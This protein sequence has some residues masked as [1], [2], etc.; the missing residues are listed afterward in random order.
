[1]KKIDKKIY[2]KTNKQKVKVRKKIP[3]LNILF[4]ILILILS[5]I[6][7]LVFKNRENLRNIF[8]NKNKIKA[9]QA[10][11]AADLNIGDI[12]Y[13]DHKRAADSNNEKKQTVTIKPGDSSHPGSGYN[14]D[15]T[16]NVKDYNTTWR[17][18][19]KKDDGSVTL[20]SNKTVATMNIKAA[21]GYIWW[22]HNAHKVASIFG[23][24]KGAD[25]GKNKAGEDIGATKGITY[26]VGSGIN[27]SPDM[28][29]SKDRGTWTIGGEYPKDEKDKINISGAKA[30]TLQE[31]EEKFEINKE[32]VNNPKNGFNTNETVYYGGP[33]Y[34]NE[35]E[36]TMTYVV[37]RNIGSLKQNWNNKE[38][39]QAKNSRYVMKDSHY[40]WNKDNIT[41][42]NIPNIKYKEILFNGM[43]KWC[44]LATNAL[45]VT[46]E[47][48]KVGYN[49]GRMTSEGLGS[50]NYLLIRSNGSTWNEFGQSPSLR[51][52]VFMNKNNNY[53]T[54]E[55]VNG[56]KAW[57]LQVPVTKEKKIEIDNYQKLD[58]EPQI[59]LVQNE[60]KIKANKENNRYIANVTYEEGIKRI[61]K[62]DD[63]KFEEINTKY[64]IEISNLPAGYTFKIEGQDTNEIDVSQKDNI[65]II[66]SKAGQDLPARD[67][68]ASDLHIGD[69][70]Y[71]N[72]KYAPNKDHEAN[73]TVTIGKGSASTPGS[74][75]TNHNP[76]P[77][78]DP[79]PPTPPPPPTP[80]VP[81][82]PTPEP[83][84]PTPEPTPYH[85]LRV[86]PPKLPD[87][88]DSNMQKFNAKEYNTTWRVWDK[89]A[90]GRVMLVSN[91]TVANINTKGAVG[92]IWWEHNAHKISSIFGYGEGADTNATK[93]TEYKVGSGI[94]D[95]PD[96]TEGDKGDWK[97]GE[98]PE[99]KI[100][101][102]G[103]RS[104]T[105]PEVEEKLGITDK[106]IKDETT[107]SWIMSS[108]PG[109]GNQTITSIAYVVQRDIESS[110]QNWKTEEDRKK[111][112]AKNKVPDGYKM[113]DKYY[114]WQKDLMPETK[115]KEMLFNQLN[116][117]G[118]LATNV[119]AVCCRGAGVGFINAGVSSG[120]VGTGGGDFL[121]YSTDSGWEERANPSNLRVA[122]YLKSK[123]RYIPAGGNAWDI[124]EASSEDK[125]VKLKVLNLSSASIDKIG[126]KAS[127]VNTD[128]VLLEDITKESKTST[129][130]NE[131]YEYNLNIKK[132]SG[133][134][135]EGE[136]D[137]ATFSIIDNKYNVEITGIPEWYDYK[138]LGKEGKQ[139]DLDE[140]RT[141]EYELVIYPKAGKQ[142]VQVEYDGGQDDETFKAKG[143]I[144]NVVI[145]S[146]GK[147]LGRTDGVTLK[148]GV[149]SVSVDNVDLF[150]QTNNSIIKKYTVEFERS[151]DDKS[152][153]TV[154]YDIDKEK[155][156][157]KY[158]SP[159]KEIMVKVAEDSKKYLPNIT[160][161]KLKLVGDWKET[162]VT[163]KPIDFTTKL[164]V[165]E[166][167][168]EGNP[169][170]YSLQKDGNV[171]GYY[172]SIDGFNVNLKQILKLPFTGT[173]LSGKNIAIISLGLFGI[174]LLFR[175]RK[176]IVLIFKEY[177]MMK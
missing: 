75:W 11:K 127:K 150:D 57:D 134:K 145:K 36:T 159:N 99:D 6:T 143:V 3:I 39:G 138:I 154:K 12:V 102:S 70:V 67:L 66:I 97:I 38:K 86:Y 167:D 175:F 148:I 95:A 81:E 37:Q 173:E 9:P 44:G 118:A 124:Y 117:Y 50:A 126:I 105:L 169:I 1:M 40:Y 14:T 19:D 119:L 48:G 69:I 54:A 107:S 25:V 59:N 111:G 84:L 112:K 78:P 83:E 122:V 170:T 120:S 149:N 121:V 101:I 123:I 53:Y 133:Q 52:M 2:K 21:V 176:K 98:E 51:V 131:K 20:I 28:E 153:H 164:N 58:F 141:L 13:Y 22:E 55:Q 156:V 8:T 163:L 10:S 174:A 56:E 68:D 45:S 103:A 130:V 166:R 137:D 85:P 162:P 47:G 27:N 49:I 7:S 16:F 42:E 34:G 80:P 165:P 132:Y 128:G 168:E 72:H 142:A 108:D 113:T 61:G 139:I 106:S 136:G 155:L 129:K 71:Y 109:Y 160:E 114:Y 63:A 157:V 26:K 93:G 125:N 15:Q 62:G 64:N 151:S 90:D 60:K 94:D 91:K 144:G 110:N 4:L 76:D 65:K 30:L 24:G 172:V 32:K 104:L 92:H 31:V 29:E 140:D 100:H 177:T 116:R 152:L 82:P 18:W 96:M 35:A 171:P 147:E 89:L 79:D 87:N 88:P 74:G 41:S 46:A 135:R 161:I 158:V 5:L 73:Q 33:Y 17:V 77:D 43:D 146:D 115:Y 23:Y